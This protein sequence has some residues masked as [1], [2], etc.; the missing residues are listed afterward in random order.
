MAE[1]KAEYVTPGMPL[2]TANRIARLRHTKGWGWLATDIT[3]AEYA[4]RVPRWATREQ[5]LWRKALP[6]GLGGRPWPA[7]PT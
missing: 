5:V 3:G 6:D 4:Q 2:G 7:E 1:E